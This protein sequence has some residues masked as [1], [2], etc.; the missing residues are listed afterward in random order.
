MKKI[1]D[2]ISVDGCNDEEYQTHLVL[3]AMMSSLLMI[4]C[5]DFGDTDAI[6][7]LEF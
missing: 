7:C 5:F 2:Y 6:V 4:A 3:W 1:K